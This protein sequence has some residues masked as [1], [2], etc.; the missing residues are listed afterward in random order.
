MKELGEAIGQGLVGMVA[1]LH[2]AQGDWSRGER[3]MVVHL[4]GEDMV[5][6]TPQ[7][8]RPGKLPRNV[9]T[10]VGDTSCPH[11]RMRA[12]MHCSLPGEQ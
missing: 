5:L 4:A 7:H 10:R 11:S 9:I 2:R 3:D 6:E 1:E 8:I 12:S